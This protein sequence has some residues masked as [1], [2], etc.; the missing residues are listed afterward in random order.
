LGEF[1]YF[2]YGKPKLSKEGTFQWTYY[3][4]DNNDTEV[5]FFKELSNGN[6]KYLGRKKPIME[7]N[8][9][10]KRVNEN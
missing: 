5:D 2:P 6:F 10:L 7:N 3:N 9:S 4:P 8:F 1:N